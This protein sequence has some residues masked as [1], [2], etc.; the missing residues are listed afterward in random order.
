MKVPFF[1]NHFEVR[2]LRRAVGA[3]RQQFS[4]MG[5]SSVAPQTHRNPNKHAFS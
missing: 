4:D 1:L 2:G 3:L 5:M